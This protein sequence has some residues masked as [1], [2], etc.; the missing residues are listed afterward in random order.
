MT[1]A[2]N[3]ERLE[4]ILS[5][6]R[7]AIVATIKNDGSP[8]VTPV[9]FTWDGEVLRFSTTKGRAKYFNL[10]RDARVTVLIDSPQG[11]A[12]L[13]GQAEMDDN[14]QSI[15]ERIRAIRRKNQG[16]EKADALTWEEL[17]LEQRVLITVRPER[18][19]GP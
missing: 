1:T 12:V 17:A 19:I 13:Y 11:Y 10:R 15:L 14:P 16:D 6:K 18:I 5:Q 2:G 8:Q 4:A 3:Q 7:N 9:S